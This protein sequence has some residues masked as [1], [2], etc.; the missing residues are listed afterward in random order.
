[1][2]SL[3]AKYAQHLLDENKVIQAV[4][5]YRKANYFLDAAK[6]LNDLARSV[7]NFKLLW[8]IRI[9]KIIKNK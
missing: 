8:F 9:L 2:N 3:L 5:L 1:L 6:L 7:N 4:E